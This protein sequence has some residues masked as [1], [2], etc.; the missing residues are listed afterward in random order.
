MAVR[1]KEEARGNLHRCEVA[2]LL[3]TD[4]LKVRLTRVGHEDNVVWGC[5]SSASLSR[6]LE[7]ID[8]Q[9]RGH[10]RMQVGG[11][12]VKPMYDIF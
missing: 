10:V 1:C 11:V 6:R 4:L 2:S 5:P 8:V 3:S 7:V 12:H 9:T